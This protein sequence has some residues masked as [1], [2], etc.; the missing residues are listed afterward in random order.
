MTEELKNIDKLYDAAVNSSYFSSL[1]TPRSQK[2]KSYEDVGSKYNEYIVEHPELD[3]TAK[4]NIY[5]KL[6]NIYSCMNNQ[7][8]LTSTKLDRYSILTDEELNEELANLKEIDILKFLDIAD[9]RMKIKFYKYL[10]ETLKLKSKYVVAFVDFI[11]TT[12]EIADYATY[13]EELFRANLETVKSRKYAELLIKLDPEKYKAYC[14]K[15]D[16]LPSNIDY[17]NSL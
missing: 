16:P 2:I 10:I 9:E 3:K 7:S 14:C 15:V 6:L 17:Y 12:S 5:D 1:L 13:I 4:L 11:A 8:K